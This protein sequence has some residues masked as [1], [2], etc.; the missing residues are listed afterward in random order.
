MFMKYNEFID[1]K[2]HLGG[3]FGFDATFYPDGAFEFQSALIEWAC[4]KGRAAIFADCGLGKTLMQIAW[5]QNVVRH[6]NGRVLILVPLAVARQT[7]READRIGVEVKVCRDGVLPSQRIVIA[8]YEKLHLFTPSNFVGVVCDESSILKNFDGATKQA[9]TEF[10]RGLPYRLLCTA[11][12]APN[13]YIELGTSAEALGVMGYIDMLKVFF[14]AD[15]NT[16]AHGGAGGRHARSRDGKFRFRGHAE[17]E[18]WRWV[19]SWA[20]AIRKPSDLGFS[21]RGFDLPQLSTREHVVHARTRQDGMLF[22]M[23]AIGLKEQREERRRTINERCEMAADLASNVDCSVSW[24][25][26]NTEGDLLA[27]L[28]PDS[29]QVSGADTDERKEEIFDAFASGQI[30]RLVTKPT[31]AGFGLNWQHCAHSTFFPSHSFEQWYQSVRR[32]WRF[33]QQRPVTIDIVCSE[34]E[35]GVLKNLM[36]KSEAASSM[37]QQLVALMGNEIT[38]KAKRSTSTDFTTPEWL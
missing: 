36:R 10:M 3:D 20:R 23:P 13:D 12:A 2:R 28:I 38:V 31:I 14:K 19:C 4:R 16:Y 21:D 32:F 30:K 1:A 7:E 9:V 24:C 27:R 22:D 25:H 6:T 18:F 35:S 26:L 17:R 34:G 37:F 8:N 33:G 5:A 15:S 11:T 29:A